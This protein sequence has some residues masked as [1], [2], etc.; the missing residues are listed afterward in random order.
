MPEIIQLDEK[1]RIRRMDSMNWTVEL[2]RPAKKGRSVGKPT[3]D[4]ANYGYGPFF[5]N[6]AD[7]LPWL[8]DNLHASTPGTLTLEGAIAEY[9]GIADK[10]AADVEKAMADA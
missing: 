6:P 7:A 8:L 4:C 5:K 1:T 9:R 3:W 10:L 2:L